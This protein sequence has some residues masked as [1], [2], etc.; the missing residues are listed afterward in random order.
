MN[1]YGYGGNILYV[2]LTTGIVKSEVL[3]E[4]LARKYIGGCGI[5]LR[6]LYDLLKPGIAPHSPEN[7][8]IISAGPLVGTLV[9][10]SNK[11]QMLTKFAIPANKEQTKYYVGI[12]SGGSNRFGLMMKSAGYDQIVVTGSANKPVYLKIMNDHVEICSAADLWGRDIYETT[13]ELMKRYLGCGVIA[14]G[15]GGESM[16][17]LSLAFVDARNTIGKGAASVMGSKNLKAISVYGDR[18]VK[19]WDPKLLMKLSID[20]N[21]T[22]R[23]I[24]YFNKPGI[25][26][27]SLGKKWA[28]HYPPKIWK[29][30]LLNSKGCSSCTLTCKSFHKINTGAFSGNTLSTGVFMLVPIYGR[31]LELKDYGESMELLATAN[32]LGI[33]FSSMA[34][35]TKFLIRL[36]ERGILTTKD[37]DGLDLRLGDI[38]SCLKLAHKIAN[39]DG[40]GDSMAQGWHALASRVG[41]DPNTDPDGDGI[42]KGT[43]TLYDG[44]FTPMDPTRFMCV[45]NPRGGMHSHPITY[46]PGRSVSVIRE[47]CQGMGLSEEEIE[48]VFNADD[49]NCGRLERHC[50]DG[51]AIWFSLGVCSKYVMYGIYNISPLSA[52]YTA[53]TG[54]QITPEELKKAGERIWN[55]Y[56]IINIREGFGREDDAFPGLWV[57]TIDEPI[58]GEIRLRDYF[59][60]PLQHKDLE[61]MLDDYY[62]E[63]GWNSSE[64]IPSEEKRKALGLDGLDSNRIP[65]QAL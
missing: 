9:P 3:N 61:K 54:F 30:T 18:G 21:E 8:I 26:N 13:D 24:P 10:G 27:W 51:E 40:I 50:E 2:N 41:V 31:R 34:G 11:I 63:R 16:A 17:P 15:R 6:L 52:L 64:G 49:F 65:K 39:R 43:S 57:K 35:M 5:G 47:F 46:Y 53:V 7:P 42:V 25:A 32:R 23:Q 33:D 20:I 36:K 60:K 48:P 37:T 59:G 14:I 38:Q 19:V 55:L 58:K 62:D 22:I 44:R 28:V 29:E 1:Y 12:G 45:V 4:T 56:K